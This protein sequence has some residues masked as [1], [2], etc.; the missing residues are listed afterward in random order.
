MTSAAQR[1]VVVDTET[2]GLEVSQGHRV[3]EVGC[4]ELLGRRLTGATFHHYINP[5]R[6]I[7][8]GAIEVHGIT[9]AQVRDKP[10]FAALAEELLAFL[11]GAQLL[12]HNAAFDVGFLNN[13]FQ[14][15]GLGTEVVDAHC[16]VVDTLALARHKHPSQR[17]SLD[18]LCKRYAVDNSQRAYHGALMDA[19]ILADVYLAMTGGQ[20]TLLGAS[21]A[22]LAALPSHPPPNA[23]AIDTP[24]IKAS[25]EELAQHEKWLQLLDQK[26]AGETVWR[27]IER[28]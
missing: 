16:E 4:V 25:G 15:A 7:D 12:M 11:D 13:E 20:A 27:Q 14:L 19:E 17:N 1:Q 28:H 26:S 24:L 2:T 10:R 6:E 3:I 21:Q 8:P 5:Q 23:A 22:G 18:A 9:D